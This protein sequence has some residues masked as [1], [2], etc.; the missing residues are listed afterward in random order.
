MTEDTH[1]RPF[2]G[3]DAE[4]LKARMNVQAEMISAI[5][6]L[7]FSN[8]EHW[9]VQLAQGDENIGCWIMA[10]QHMLPAV[11]ATLVQT[12]TRVIEMADE[13]GK[14]IGMAARLSCMSAFNA[15][16]NP[17]FETQGEC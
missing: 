1:S 17:D 16:N 11:A 5:Q 10:E 3:V 13:H 4:E 12:L 9:T 8:N 14:E 2:V 6:N 7:D 15:I